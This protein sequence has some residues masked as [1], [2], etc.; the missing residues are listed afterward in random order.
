[1][2]RLDK[3]LEYFGGLSPEVQAAILTGFG[4]I[5]A[6]CIVGIIALFTLNS[7]L[8]H[9]RTQRQ[10]N[11]EENIRSGIYIEAGLII[12]AVMQALTR[13]AS[14]DHD[15]PKLMSDIA[16][17]MSKLNR[18]LLVS[19]SK[20]IDALLSFQY[21]VN[22]VMVFQALKRVPLD[23]NKHKI[24]A[25]TTARDKHLQNQE[26]I[27]AELKNMV[28]S[29]KHE[30]IDF[31]Q[32]RLDNEFSLYSDINSEL[33]E[34]LKENAYLQFDLIEAGM[35]ESATLFTVDRTVLLEAIRDQLGMPKVPNL[36]H[37][38]LGSYEAS[39]RDLQNFIKD[40]RKKLDSM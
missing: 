6:A 7:Q 4:S 27:N 36:K 16:E 30:Y 22:R 25:L 13:L 18:I 11:Y 38:L 21:G 17:S 32:E 2:D 34:L 39:K 1:V 33:G 19:D 10:K 5:F 24:V 8:K 35:T 29:G 23:A 26:L 37:K 15:G 31:L 14:V 12:D 28:V 20:T 40:M 9:D 3:Y